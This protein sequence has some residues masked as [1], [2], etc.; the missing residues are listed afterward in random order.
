[1]NAIEL[2]KKDHEKVKKLFEQYDS[3]G[4]RRRDIANMV[5]E[6]LEAHSRVEEDV[7]YPAVRAKAKKD[8]KELIKH[9]I[10]EHKEVDDL[11]NELRSMDPEEEDFDDRFQELIEDVEHHIDLEENETFPKAE[12][13][14]GNDLEDLGKQI[15][16][17]KETAKAR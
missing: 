17:E 3:D 7:F 14:L 11:I 1:M 10:E 2:L 12:Q 15:E 4:D 5:F 8:G 16:E 9:S 13:L 6:E